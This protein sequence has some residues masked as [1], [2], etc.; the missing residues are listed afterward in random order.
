M[1]GV[2][3][4]NKKHVNTTCGVKSLG[5]GNL[6]P[7]PCGPPT[8]TTAFLAAYRVDTIFVQKRVDQNHHSFPDLRVLHAHPLTKILFLMWCGG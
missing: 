6:W 8:V 2:H 1:A 4:E 3:S 7:S 5:F